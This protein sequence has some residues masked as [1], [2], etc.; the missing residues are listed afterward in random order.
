M[1]DLIRILNELAVKWGVTPVV[2]PSCAFGED[3]HLQ[4]WHPSHMGGQD[5][6]CY[7]VLG[8]T[9]QIEEH[10]DSPIS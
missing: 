3:E 2:I 10:P 7:T 4:I 8:S 6:P 9:Q 1:Q 5:M